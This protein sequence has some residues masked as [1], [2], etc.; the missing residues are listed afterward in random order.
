MAS[1]AQQ[2]IFRIERRVGDQGAVA[3]AAPVAV[4]GGANDAALAEMR[5]LIRAIDAKVSALPK[6]EEIEERLV[7][8][9]LD[10]QG[11]IEDTKEEI[12]A[13]RHPKLK[14]DKIQR[15]SLQLDAIVEQTEHATSTIL[16]SAE[17]LE[18]GIAHI[19]DTHPTDQI[20]ANTADLMTDAVTAIY[21][22]SNFQDITGQRIRK[23]VDV[24]K[25]IEDRLGRMVN[26][27]GAGEIEL[28]PVP[29]DDLDHIDDD[30]ALTGPALKHQH[31]EAA[32]A[33]S[34]D[35]IDALFA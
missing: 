16:E 21:E 2:K 28:L 26:L 19:R 10:M 29:E 11:R 14:E 30:V 25:Y 24:L 9:V 35:D 15:A 8:D 20:V 4:V 7:K 31:T 3:P 13:L 1:Q 18:E 22:A 34:Q 27:W 5:D 6:L 33:I 17:K 23:V 12:A 32:P